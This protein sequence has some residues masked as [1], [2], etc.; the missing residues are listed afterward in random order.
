MTISYTALKRRFTVGT[1]IRVTNHAYPYLSGERTVLVAQTNAIAS[2]P[3]K[4]AAGETVD[5]SWCYW[6]KVAEAR[7]EGENTIHLLN[8][9]GT[10]RFSY[11]ILGA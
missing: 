11:T 2:G 6:P 10:V 7:V 3:C 4:N 5:K 1:R 8:Q 9:D